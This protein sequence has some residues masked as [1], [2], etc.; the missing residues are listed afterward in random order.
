MFRNA[1]FATLTALL[2]AF[3]AVAAKAADIVDTAVSAGNFETLVCSPSAPMEQFR[4]IA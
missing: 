2:L 3:S 4:L 1:L